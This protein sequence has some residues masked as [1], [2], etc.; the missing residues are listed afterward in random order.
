MA[1]LI[2]NGEKNPS[3][4]RFDIHTNEINPHKIVWKMVK[5]WCD[6]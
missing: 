1:D 3:L 6:R 4:N 5:Y 2:I